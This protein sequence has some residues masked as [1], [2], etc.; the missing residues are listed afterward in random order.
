VHSKG[1]KTYLPKFDVVSDIDT[2]TI[3]VEPTHLSIG[4][5]YSEIEKKS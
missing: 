5:Q 4:L 2:K 3:Y 1:L